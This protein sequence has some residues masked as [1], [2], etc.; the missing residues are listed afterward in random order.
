MMP[1]RK[2]LVLEDDVYEALQ[3][4]KEL[5]GLPLGKLGNAILRAHIASAFLEN[6]VGQRLVE[7]GRVTAEEYRDILDQAA[8]NLR[9]SFVPRMPPIERTG[10]GEM[11]AGSWSIQNVFAPPGGA[12]Q[13]LEAWAR[14]SL[15]QAMGQHSHASDEYVIALGGKTLFVM[16]GAPCTLRKNGVFEVPAGV[17]HSATPLDA[18]SHLVVVVIPA[19]PEYD[20]PNRTH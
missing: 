14:D 15:Q 1:T 12:F 3:G 16:S 8:R 17:I 6:S 2:H 11:L 9:R 10:S 7:M 13:I 19:A 20:P 4:R 18:D 5:S